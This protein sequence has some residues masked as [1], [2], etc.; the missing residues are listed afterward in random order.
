VTVQGMDSLLGALCAAELG[1]VNDASK[2]HFAELRYEVSR[3]LRRLVDDLP[4]PDVTID[5]E[6]A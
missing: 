5:A 2:R 4:E 6:A 1:T 3:L